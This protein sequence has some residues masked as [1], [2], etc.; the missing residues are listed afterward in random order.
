MTSLSSH[1]DCCR[2]PHHAVNP[3]AQYYLVDLDTLAWVSAIDVSEYPYT[4]G[5]GLQHS[6]PKAVI[7]FMFKV[8]N[9]ELPFT[10]N[11]KDTLLYTATSDYQGLR[12]NVTHQTRTVMDTMKLRI[13]TALPDPTRPQLFTLSPSDTLSRFSDAEVYYMHQRQYVIVP[14]TWSLPSIESQVRSIL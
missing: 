6:D 7:P 9:N 12:W 13:G 8:S 3:T 2:L 5:L 11:L 1:A 4:I 14:F 10:D